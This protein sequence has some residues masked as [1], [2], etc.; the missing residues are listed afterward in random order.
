MA[1]LRGVLDLA[2][3]ASQLP[4]GSALGPELDL[5]GAPSRPILMIDAD[6]G[7]AIETSQ[8]DRA[9]L[10]LRSAR[11][12]VVAVSRSSEPPPAL[13]QAVDISISAGAMPPADRR[14][15]PV[16][17]LAAALDQLRASV[18]ANPVA[19]LTLTWLMRR[20]AGLPAADALV[21]ESSAYSTLLA[22]REFGG[23]LASR[24][25]PR[26]IEA[27][28]RVRV[29][30]DGGVLQVVLSRPGR[31][32]AVDAAMRD[33]LREALAIA[34]A[35]PALRVVISAEGPSFSAGGDLDEFGTATDVASAHLVRV[36]GSVG[37]AIH[38]IRDRVTVR[39]QG[40]CMGAGVELPAFAGRVIAARDAEFALPEIAMG[41][42]PGA[43]GTVSITAR[44]GRHRA[45]W[46]ALTG[47][48]LD[49]PTALEWGLVDAVE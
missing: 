45:L 16:P 24:R 35:D 39:V 41:L 21:E 5:A 20:A 32:N 4:D 25:A 27:G 30:R 36:V 3:L 17:E 9:V 19:A 7:A 29:A 22:G 23:W 15:V 26:P 14:T 38:R 44:I 47:T 33:A 2:S 46:F 43:G 12:I 40:V 1:T 10:N 8:L 31:R 28:E 49:A 34:E 11:A 48:R 18:M 6:S 37:A 13:T 42:I